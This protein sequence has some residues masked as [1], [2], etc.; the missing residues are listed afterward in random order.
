M[1]IN[2]RFGETTPIIFPE[3]DWILQHSQHILDS[4]YDWTGRSLLVVSGDALERAQQL[5]EAPFALLS[6]GTE[7]DPIFNYGNRQA[8]LQFGYSWAEFTQLP[9][10]CSAE[11]ILQ[12]ERSALLAASRSQGIITNFQAIRIDRWGNPFSIQNGILWNLRDQQGQYIGQA[13]TYS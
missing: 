6:H 13:A 11:P 9:S 3:S 2:D 12:E 10:R 5:F 4:F 8:L 1:K 7:A